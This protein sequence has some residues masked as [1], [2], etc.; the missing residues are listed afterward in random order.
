MRAETSVLRWIS[1]PAS[2]VRR[3]A[4]RAADRCAAGRPL[5]H[6]GPLYSFGDERL[7]GGLIDSIIA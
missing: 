6:R 4:P 2:L 1:A 7:E 3:P 5:P